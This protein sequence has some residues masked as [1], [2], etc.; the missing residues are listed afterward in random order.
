MRFGVVG[1]G[2]AGGSFAAALGS[3]GWEIGAT[4]G[5]GDDA[6]GAAQD[7]DVLL[8]AV[9]DRVVGVVANVIQPGPAAVLH[10]AGSLTLEPLVAHAR[11]GSVHPL[12]A[13]PDAEVGAARLLDSCRFAVA[14]DPAA[15]QV[16]EA[17]GG[18][19]FTVEDEHRQLYHAGAAIA[20]NHLVALAEQAQRLARAAG[21]PADV[22]NQLM[23]ASLHNVATAD[24][25]SALTGPAARADWETVRGHAEAIEATGHPT[26]RMLYL[27][28][29]AEAA[30]MAGY[31]LPDDVF[32]DD[33]KPPND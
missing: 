20:S 12:M 11:R 31:R 3:V 18:Q 5:S 27:M 13:L 25:V 15:T 2:R 9:P 6:S 10:V 16:A 14:G 7:V 1:M 19:A 22:Y 33:V 8:L 23:I 24:P 21:V 4:W 32:P 26:D 29:A 17:L 28:F 30:H